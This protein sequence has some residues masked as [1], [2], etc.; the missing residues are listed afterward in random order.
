MVSSKA[1]T[2]KDYLSELPADRKRDIA[3]VRAAIRQNLPPGYKEMMLFG[4]IV[5][6]IPLSRYPAT[7]NGAPLITRGSRRRRTTWL[8]T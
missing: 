7:Y 3:R 5:Y 2:V 1:A 6:C 4:A 8:C